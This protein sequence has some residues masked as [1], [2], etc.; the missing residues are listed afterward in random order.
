[1]LV[2][3]RILALPSGVVGAR[4]A[5][6]TAAFWTRVAY[7]IYCFGALSSAGLS[8]SVFLHQTSP[9]EAK[10]GVRTSPHLTV[11]PQKNERK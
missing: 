5:V 2:G 9:Q 3:F 10:T 4:V 11:I 8:N 1:M 7:A 6:V